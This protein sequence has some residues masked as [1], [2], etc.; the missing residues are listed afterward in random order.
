MH[1]IAL[2]SRGVGHPMARQAIPSL[3]TLIQQR[4]PSSPPLVGTWS[5]LGS[6]TVAETLVSQSK[7]DF[8][9]LD[10]EHGLLTSPDG[11]LDSARALESR[12]CSTAVRV[13]RLDPHGKAIMRALDIGCTT[14]VVPN[15]SNG[16][17]AALAVAAGYFPQQWNYC[18]DDGEEVNGFRGC[19]PFV[20][21][22]G[23]VDPSDYDCASYM[24][25]QNATTMVVPMIESR[26]AAENIESI[27]STPGLH[28]CLFGPF[29][30]SVSEGLGG[31][32]TPEV[33]AL[34]GR[35]VDACLAAGVEPI[36]P[37][38]GATREEAGEAAQVWMRR[39]VNIF[40][41]GLDV[42]FLAQRGRT[43]RDAIVGACG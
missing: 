13:P 35:S 19:N 25:E 7:F 24:S 20:R 21:A 8:V 27:V 32:R 29:D 41:V 42:V 3:R 10:A 4:L 23:S 34:I 26:E 16:D 1:K 18:A 11:V 22:A 14:V 9:V 36:M 6:P 15:I 5:I 43:F 31:A 2:G 39:G 33:E 40:T 28:A 17:D 38:F 12:G 37:V 30:L